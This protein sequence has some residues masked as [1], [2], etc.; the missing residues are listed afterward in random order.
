MRVILRGAPRGRR[1]LP[2]TFEELAYFAIDRD[3][4]ARSCTALRFHALPVHVRKGLEN[5]RFA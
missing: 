5:E 3:D 4:V 1:N 2:W